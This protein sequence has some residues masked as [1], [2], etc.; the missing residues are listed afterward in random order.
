MLSK[1]IISIVV[2]LF[3]LFTVIPTFQ[4]S[5][6][7]EAIHLNA[8]QN[9]V[10]SYTKACSDGATT[11]AIAG[12]YLFVLTYTEPGGVP[13]F[14]TFPPNINHGGVTFLDIAC[15]PYVD[16][17]YVF[18]TMGTAGMEC[19]KW[20]SNAFT[21]MDNFSDGSDFEQM[22]IQRPG[23]NNMIHVTK[24]NAGGIHAYY[25]DVTTDLFHD[26]FQSISGSLGF[27]KAIWGY[28]NDS[29][30]IA[31]IYACHYGVYPPYPLQSYSFVT[32]YALVGT[33]TGYDL[34]TDGMW[35][36][37][38]GGKQYLYAATNWAGLYVY[39]INNGLF[40]F[41]TSIDYPGAG[42]CRAVMGDGTPSRQSSYIWAVW[43]DA[44]RL[45]TFD[46]TNLHL[47]TSRTDGT[48]G[49]IGVL[50]SWDGGSGKHYCLAS[51]TTN[52]VRMYSTTGQIVYVWKNG[53][54]GW[55]DE[56]HVH[57]ITEGINNVT[58]GG[59]VYVWAG[60]Y[61]EHVWVNKSMTIVGNSSSTVIMNYAGYYSTILCN[62]PWV[63]ISG[64]KLINSGSFGTMLQ[65]LSHSTVSN[66]IVSGV[67]GLNGWEG[68]DISGDYS[69]V[70]GC[71]ITYIC[72]TGGIEEGMMVAGDHNTISNCNFINA[73]H[74]V[75]WQAGDSALRILS[76]DDIEVSNC[77]F[78]ANY[79]YYGAIDIGS[80]NN[81]VIRDSYF[82]GN[83]IGIFDYQ[84]YN[85]LVYN[86]TFAT[87]TEGARIVMENGTIRN[88]HFFGSSG[89]DGIECTGY[90]GDD[91]THIE[92]SDFTGFIQNAIYCHSLEHLSISGCTFTNSHIAINLGGSLAWEGGPTFLM[93]GTIFNNEI[94]GCYQG[95]YVVS[96][97]ATIT[98][99]NISACTYGISLNGSNY[100]STQLDL[101]RWNV[102]SHNILTGNDYGFEFDSISIDNTIYN[103]YVDNTINVD[104]AG[105]NF[106]NTTKTS[107]IN[108]MGGHYLGG[109]YWS[110]YNG[111]DTN[112][113]GIGDTHLP[114]YG[115]TSIH[116][117]GDYLPLK[118]T[119]HH[120]PVFGT[121][122]PI[123]N[124]IN[125]PLTFTWGIPINDAGGTFGWTIE[126]GGYQT[127]TVNP[128]ASNGTKT[129]GFS[130]DLT[131]GRTYKIWVNATDG[132]DTTRA[133][134]R[135]TTKT[136]PAGTEVPP[137]NNNTNET[138]IIIPPPETPK[139][140]PPA[141]SVP[142]MYQLL[143]ADRLSKSDAEV[144]VMVIDSGVLPITYNNIQ[145]NKISAIKD[146]SYSTQY[147][148][149][150]H[151]TWVNYAIAYLLQTKIPHA[152]QISYRVFG[153]D[154]S[155][156]AT[157]FVRAL[158]TAKA[159]HVDIV[160]ISAGVLGTKDDAFA[161]ACEDLRNNG[162]IVVVAAGNFGPSPSSIASPGISD[163][164]IAVAAEDPIEIGQYTT[165]THMRGVLDL[166][167]DIICPWSS[168]GPITGVQKPD[169]TAP[170]ES[171][172][173]PWLYEERLLSGTSMATPLVSGGI[174][175]VYANNKLEIDIVKALYFWDKTTI[176]QLFEDSLKSSAYKKGNIN[177]W[178]S[179]IVQFDQMNS[180]VQAGLHTK[181]I[182]GFAGIFIIVL[183]VAFFIHRSHQKSTGYKV[184]KWV[185]K[186]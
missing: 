181:L 84:G 150:G 111:T 176:P 27:Y 38:K 138:K 18:V 183:I 121:P 78:T 73:S 175:L 174:A 177:D 178:G 14:G 163:S 31:Y 135:F 139:Y 60:T 173:G 49:Y 20:Q 125:Q 70:H 99:N 142:E 104:D 168:R 13:Q 92:D 5:V 54:S 34:R 136:K 120:P 154:G 182:I 133:W 97:N 101:P 35:G 127:G 28:Y 23:L 122:I 112:G 7:A 141:F 29:S 51:C 50:A 58:A 83:N 85:T 118:Q 131:Y 24:G 11:F 48:G 39:Q 57:T 123:N 77:S 137:Q 22:W 108:I 33:A 107:G 6:R 41:K 32:S 21:Y 100:P 80:T 155:S 109:N 46:G 180:N 64:I 65:I 56:T 148:E 10:S 167:D 67:N 40:T 114:Y 15:F 113:D 129:F 152:K 26:D 95:I 105:T 166:R 102:I 146:V 115:T 69:T 147:D 12:S 98:N 9:L 79:G 89:Y 42:T 90:L 156:T 71:T 68:I 75:S 126:W 159:M 96:A 158:E 186:L 62:S 16:R 36:E 157:E 162:I 17:T 144:T 153:P 172:M 179:G 72:S 116:N 171:I 53:P 145:L 151:G 59:T 88:C 25:Y 43:D 124:S 128:G 47:L 37:F 103:N 132:V 8:T 74:G 106:W 55:Y 4:P 169:V 87:S 2:L 44:I 94:T 165:E 143:H 91:H 170:G 117:G 119:F 3:F 30:G 184:P 164:V 52:G 66:C 134:Y 93:E 110:D 140:A 19:Y 76:G 63:N 61:T 1:K 185:K 86:C 45:F 130:G 82:S 160:S 149:N 81:L 161:K